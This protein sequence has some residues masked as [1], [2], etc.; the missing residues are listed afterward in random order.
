MQ[1]HKA[2]CEHVVPGTNH[3]VDCAWEIGPDL[4]D[5]FEVIVTSTGN[6]LKHLSV[7]SACPVV[8]TITVVCQQKRY[9]ADLQKTFEEEPVIEFLGDRLVWELAETYLRRCFP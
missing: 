2:A 9:I 1:E 5:V 7:L 3:R 6:I 4:L 8:R